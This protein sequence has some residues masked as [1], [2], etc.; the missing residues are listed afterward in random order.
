[1]T[2]LILNELRAIGKR[3]TEA[4]EKRQGDM[5]KNIWNQEAAQDRN[6]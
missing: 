5:T 6:E 1:M 2:T 4:E 3:I